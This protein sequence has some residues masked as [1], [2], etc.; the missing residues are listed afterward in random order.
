LDGLSKVANTY[1]WTA[2]SGQLVYTLP[3]GTNLND[4]WLE[5]AVGGATLP[6]SLVRVDSA[7]QLTLLVNSTDIPTGIKVTARWVEPFIPATTGHKN[8]HE[9]GGFDEIDVTKLKN[10]QENIGT[11]LSIITPQKTPKMKG[12]SFYFRLDTDIS[13]ITDSVLNQIKNDGVTHAVLCPIIRN[14]DAID[15]NNLSMDYTTGALTTLVNRILAKGLSIIFKFHLARISDG[16]NGYGSNS[17]SNPSVFF[18]NLQS[19]ILTTLNV[20]QNISLVCLANESSM[21]TQNYRSN[22]QTLIAAIRTQNPTIKITNSPTF[23]DIQNDLC[24]FWDLCDYIGTNIYPVASYSQV[25]TVREFKNSLYS[26]LSSIG[27]Q[28]VQKLYNLTKKY[29][30]DFIITE[31]G[32]LPYEYQGKDTGSW[33]ALGNYNEQ[34]QANYYQAMFDIFLNMEHCAGVFIWSLTDAY[35]FLNRQAEQVVINSF[36]EGQ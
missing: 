34:V 18:S 30:K 3:S 4:K 5:V 36:K 2:T 21:I 13:N 22:W 9:K 10:Y 32:I 26:E 28:Y 20:S 1:E 12:A 6:S 15:T 31:F 17:P 14:N 35:T 11:P 25:P 8:T 7:T 27:Y 16:K 24:V 23:A 19:I 33:T 29:N